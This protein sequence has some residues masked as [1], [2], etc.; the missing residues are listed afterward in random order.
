MS[1]LSQI[2]E[3]ILRLRDA[4]SE[5]ADEVAE[6]RSASP[7]LMLLAY[8]TPLVVVAITSALL[9]PLRDLIP[10]DIIAMAYVLT[11]IVVSDLGPTRGWWVAPISAALTFDYL[12]TRPFFSLRIYSVEDVALSVVMLVV[13][14]V[15]SRQVQSLRRRTREAEERQQ[16]LRQLNRLSNALVSSVTTDDMTQAIREALAAA[17]IRRVALFVAPRG[18]DPDAALIPHG[19]V[20]TPDESKLAELARRRSK[21]VG[22]PKPAGESGTIGPWPLSMDAS[23]YGV[24]HSTAALIPLVSPRR[25]EG[26][27]LADAGAE[28]SEVLTS[29]AR[30]IVSAANMATTFLERREL[31]RQANAAAL[32]RES[33]RIKSNLFSAVSHDIKTPLAAAKAHVTNLLVEDDQVGFEQAEDLGAAADALDR[34][35]ALIDDLL[36]LSRLESDGWRPT[37]ESCEPGE[38]VSAALARLDA[39][40]LRVRVELEG[41]PTTIRADFRQLE[42]AV[43]NLIQNALL[44]S[45]GVVRIEVS[46]APGVVRIL[47]ADSGSG[48]PDAEK[49]L[50]FDKYYRGVASTRVRGGSGL[51][52]AIVRQVALVHGGCVTVED[53]TPH[54]A[55][56]TIELPARADV[57]KEG[58]G[59][60]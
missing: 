16:D 56:F 18:S 9:F 12:F 47:V 55:R 58:E 50:V 24:L 7:A 38:I 39:D 60:E 42:R 2:Q 8:I 28:G 4:A 21:A 59:D 11:V 52:L 14:L 20:P 23:E 43:G 15:S 27:M 19:D 54:G 29:E 40:P 36:D 5:K 6:G 34:L 22:I 33:E 44:Y 10:N 48:V 31:E 49:D 3:S 35:T 26:V 46:G 41:A 45:S 57:P 30:L 53:E 32:L 13:G 1:R 37:L 51:G 17:G 25:L